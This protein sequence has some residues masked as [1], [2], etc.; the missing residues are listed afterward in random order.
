MDRIDHLRWGREAND[1]QAER[2]TGWPVVAACMAL[3]AGFAATQAVAQTLAMAAAEPSQRMEV[4]RPGQVQV[5]VGL[6]RAPARP[7]SLKGPN[8]VGELREHTQVSVPVGKSTIV[9]LPEAVRNRTVGNPQVLQAMQVSPRELYLLGM[10]LGSTNMIVQGRSGAC[11]VIDVE[12]GADPAGVQAALARLMPEEK[13][14]HVS[15]AADS[16]VLAGTVSDA[17]AA[18][19]VVEIASAFVR[20]EA[21]DVP[22]D[23]CR[24]GNDCQSK[25]E[26]K[27]PAP[28]PNGDNVR[29]VNMLSI[30]AP[31]QVMLE[32]KVAE[33]SKTLIDQLGA[34][35]NI[36]GALGSW[37]FGLLADFLSGATSLISAT[38]NNHLPL[39]L[40]LD[41][42]KRDGLV[43]ILAEPNLMA[44]SGQTASFLAG[45]KVFI[46]VP[47]SNG[48][49]GSTI[50]LQEEQFGVALKFTPTVLSGGRINLQVAPEVSELSSTGVTLTAPNISGSTILPLI[51]TRRASTT[52]QLRDG[53]SFAIG[54]LIKNN[55][56]SNVN[57]LPGL[58]EV[59]VLGALFRS[60]NFQ[61]DKTELM[62]VVTPHLAKPLGTNYRLPTDTFGQTNTPGVLLMGDMEGKKAPGA[63]P[64]PAPAQAPAPGRPA[65]P[66]APAT[67]PATPAAVPPEPAT[68][69]VP[70]LPAPAVA[71]SSTQQ[72]VPP[73]TAGPTTGP[74]TGQ[75]AARQ[76]I[77]Q[78]SR[79]P[80]VV[81]PNGGRSLP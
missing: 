19:R 72:Q 38:K 10:S 40:N 2:R 52:V 67:V 11:S 60:T 63:A 80:G 71:P 55:V 26:Q 62:F 51:T 59:P 32:V 74:T 25:N 18:Q 58:G 43:K 44:I 47:Q 24:K 27:A 23:S 6:P 75:A 20:R 64:A 35:A 56:T 53:Q 8:C 31:Q 1:R 79:P 7:V 48:T 17:L 69:V 77:A 61:Q 65:V 50:T 12:V 78:V 45:G 41:A 39:N 14:I 4:V 34:S 46:P 21:P 28:P 5:T 81:G 33:V 29:I 37:N 66:A 15:A 57:G 13:D 70:L 16:L 9:T 22:R 49:G 42:E 54:G 76:D 68:Q 30:G 36:N 73:G 3:C